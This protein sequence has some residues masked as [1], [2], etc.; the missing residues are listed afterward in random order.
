MKRELWNQGL[1]YL[2]VGLFV[3]CVVPFLRVAL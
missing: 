3:F 2:L 1:M